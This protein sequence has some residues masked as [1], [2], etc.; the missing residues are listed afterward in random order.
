MVRSIWARWPSPCAARAAR[1]DMGRYCNP[2]AQCH[3]CFRRKSPEPADPRPAT[4]NQPDKVDLD[5]KLSIGRSINRSNRSIEA[6][7]HHGDGA[8]SIPGPRQSPATLCVCV[9]PKAVA[10]RPQ[11]ASFGHVVS[12][13]AERHQSPEYP[14]RRRGQSMAARSRSA[15]AFAATSWVSGHFSLGL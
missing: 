11:R 4:R 3:F 1:L 7:D 2:G 9:A 8:R 10:F 5:A 12:F 15:V 6:S 13:R 14:R